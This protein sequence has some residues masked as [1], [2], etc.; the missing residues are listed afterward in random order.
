[1]LVGGGLQNALIVLALLSARPDARVTL[2]EREPQLGGNH[3]WCFHEGDVPAEARSW[4]D[5][6]VVQRWPEHEVIFPAYRRRLRQEYC[7]ISSAAL[8]D[9]V[10]RRLAASPNGRLLRASVRALGPAG[11]ELEDGRRVSA[12][13]VID[14][15]GP[16]RTRLEAGG[17]QKFLGLELEVAPGSAPLVPVLMDASVAQLD[18]FRF[19]YVLP[20]ASDRVLVEDTYYSTRPEL[21]EAALEE[22]VCDYARDHGLRVRG[23]LRRERGVLP[24]PVALPLHAADASPVVAGYAGG[25]FH[26]TTGYSLPVALRF[27]LLLAGAAPRAIPGAAL[28]AWLTGHRRQVRFCL[29]L[30]RMM[31]GAFAPEERY[32]VLERFY[33]LPEGTIRRFYAL[34]MNALD[35]ARIVCGRPPHGFSLARWLAK[36]Q[37]HE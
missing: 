6:L 7:A 5:A 28:E 23:V 32:H 33:R 29:W 16:D 25:L 31:F 1:M 17:Y 10:T 30:N 9:V 13:L 3:T 34:D 35:R 36:G 27:A 4:L 20:L 19:M 26:P 12:E 22:R 37:D 8:N 21:D 15:R 14:A 18:G 24:L 11:V 2:I